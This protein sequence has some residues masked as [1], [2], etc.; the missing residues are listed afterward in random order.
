MKYLLLLVVSSFCL[1]ITPRQIFA[2]ENFTLDQDNFFLQTSSG[3]QIS[4]TIVIKNTS[5]QV[6]SLKLTWQPSQHSSAH[7]IDF[8]QVLPET[9]EIQ[10]FAIGTA[11]LRFSSPANL[12]PGDYYGQLKVSTDKENST[13]SFTLRYL[14]ELTEKLEFKGAKFELN[15]VFLSLENLGNITTAVKGKILVTN[16]WGIEVAKIEIGQKDVRAGESLTIES[17]IPDL[18]PGH[19]Q[20]QVSLETGAK[21]VTQSKIYSFWSGLGMII[22]GTVG[23]LLL[24]CTFLFWLFFRKKNA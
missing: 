12:K 16:F 7:A 6:L 10:P 2:A 22:V 17:V 8:A 24:I 11:E 21:E 23:T 14:G 1:L 9:L 19:Y 3:K 4:E 13:A 5:D 15:M 20:A 18:F